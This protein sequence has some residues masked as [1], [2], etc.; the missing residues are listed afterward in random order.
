MSTIMSPARMTSTTDEHDAVELRAVLR[1]L[2][3]LQT[4]LHA[5]LRAQLDAMKRADVDGMRA[6]AARVAELTGS[7]ER[8]DMQRVALASR[9]ARLHG[10]STRGVRLSDLIAGYPQPLRSELMSLSLALRERMLAVADANR[11][12]AMV[13]GAM[14]EHFR[15]VFAAMAEAAVP[16][17]SYGRDGRTGPAEAVV[18]DAMG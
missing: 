5:V 9:L 15:A 18:L 2:L 1:A 14:A 10:L 8:I 12:V 3:S 13:S 6:A 17:A 7:F 16:P 11:V 4:E